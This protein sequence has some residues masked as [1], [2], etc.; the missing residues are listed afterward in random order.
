M[1]HDLRE[2]LQ[3]SLGAQY[4]L[5]AE[6][7]GGGMSRVFVAEDTALRRRI[8]VKVLPAEL[9]HSVSVERFN[10]E[11]LLAA[12]LQHP[13]I[14]PVLSAGETD[15]QPYYTMPFVEG[16][17]L[18]A[19]LTKGGALP[20]GEAVSLL[21]DV[22]KA[23]AY[24]HGRGVVHR[25]I[26]PDN[27][28]LTGGT[29]T[30][31][32]FGIAK[33]ISALRTRGSSETLTQ[34]GTSIGT[35]AYM[36][37][38]Q[39]L[40]D[41]ATDHRTDIYA[42]GCL[43]YELLAGRPPFTAT[44]PHKLIAAH[45]SETPAPIT[46]LRA[47]TP[48]AL[49]AL[50]GRC[51]AKDPA[52]RP[53]S[54]AEIV[55]LVESTGTGSSGNAATFRRALAIYAAAFVG[56][57]VITRVAIGAIGLPDWV[58]PGALI[59]MALGLPP[60]LLTAYVH[61]VARKRA[62]MTPTATLGGSH[63]RNVDTMASIAIKASPHAS[64]RRV[65]LGGGLAMGGFAAVVA[66]FMILRAAGIGPFG[67]LLASGRVGAQPLMLAEFA[68]RATDSTLGPTITQAVRANLDQSSAFKLLPADAVGR[69][70]QRMQKRPDAPITLALARDLA[71]REGLAAI[72]DGE[73]A[74]A[75]SGFIVTIRL[76]SPDSGQVLASFHDAA[77]GVKDL[78]QVVDGLSRKLRAKIGESLR[79]VHA[80]PALAT[81]T[82]PSLE[83]LRKFTLAYR[84]TGAGDYG[85]AITYDREAVAID[86]NF[87]LAWRHLSGAL[88]NANYPQSSIDSSARRAYALRDRVA[89][90]E[91]LVIVGWYFY[92]GPGRDRARAIAAYDS[93]AAQGDVTNANTLA[94]V[95]ASRREWG[96]ADSALLQRVRVEPGYALTYA[97]RIVV[98]LHQGRLA[99][100]E[101]TYR[102]A[103]ERTLGWPR[104]T[105]GPMR[106]SHI[107]AASGDI[108]GAEATLDSARAF[109]KGVARVL[110]L[111][112]SAAFALLR[113]KLS[114]RNRLLEDAT[115]L[116]DPRLRGSSTITDSLFA[117]LVDAWLSTASSN[118]QRLD[119]LVSSASFT[120]QPPQY[121]E[122]LAIARGYAFVGRADRARALL[123]RYQA[124]VT[125]TAAKRDEANAVHLV[126]GEIALAEGRTAE[127]IA[128]FARGDV[129]PDG[130]ASRCEYCLP[131]A[132]ARAWDAAGNQDSTIA[133]IER[134][135]AVNRVWV[136]PLER[137][138]KDRAVDFPFG[139]FFY[140][141]RFERRLG[142]LYDAAGS[143]AKAKEH[144]E[145]FLRYWSGADPSLQPVVLT[146]RRRVAALR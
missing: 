133:A 32:D 40:G 66:L 89:D 80:S 108:A 126:N 127:A 90:R 61:S 7:G 44:S 97:T 42:F 50:I 4:T 24:A 118:V 69:A 71:A 57:A 64:W 146:V 18:R 49:A 43:A 53:Q 31:T 107:R 138:A 110:D 16:E 5:G 135:L 122:Y 93:L 2:Q 145:Q 6:L 83:A 1:S 136:K 121:R 115:S 54:A 67:S 139:E 30:V 72:V 119:A 101:S 96:R 91:R 47:E 70:L 58:F 109:H 75:G 129:Q 141:P 23:L 55:S 99:A 100:A 130:P 114:Q 104:S 62:A 60:L 20:V 3:R 8:V 81:A 38:E 111:E 13:H 79:H 102:V 68:T 106:L 76:V 128:E 65:A 39:A 56:V 33:A 131:A 134:Y 17:S 143:R 116:G 92:M 63:E 142:E 86:S 29:A 59:I 9:L 48:P 124:E 132:V 117:F 14:V 25:D 105:N 98:V 73:I 140:L 88:S 52:A 77:D 15:G 27:I 28:L 82:T 74:G 94:I 34:V 78:I 45:M 41:P 144:Y 112:A 12:A 19:R 103:S 11:I 85:Q 35:P 46:T 10:R 37:P 36:S 120:Q 87:A 26:K 51:L 84:A 113:G 21:R 123:A 137:R 125:D 22:A 95:L